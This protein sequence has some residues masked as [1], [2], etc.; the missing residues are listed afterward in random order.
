MCRLWAHEWSGLEECAPSVKTM[1]E[2][3]KL[4]AARIKPF[5]KDTA[6]CDT[7][8]IEYSIQSR[9]THNKNLRGFIVQGLP[10]MVTHSHKN[11]HAAPR[12]QATITTKP[13][14]AH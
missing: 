1:G 12:P 13:S 10:S 9:Q 3:E 14:G 11:N 2:E 6:P 4:V 7:T 5:A 8:G